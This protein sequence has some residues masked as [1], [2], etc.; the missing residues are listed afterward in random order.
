M[1]TRCSSQYRQIKIDMYSDMQVFIN[2]K[3]AII[4]SVEEACNSGIDDIPSLLADVYAR[5]ISDD[6]IPTAYRDEYYLK[7]LIM[8]LAYKYCYGGGN[9]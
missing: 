1:K 2:L 7:T 6:T 8:I 3:Q 5:T 9:V 4:R